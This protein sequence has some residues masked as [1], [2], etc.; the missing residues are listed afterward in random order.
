LARWTFF[1]LPV[2]H[3]RYLRCNQRSVFQLF[4]FSISYRGVGPAIVLILEVR[5]EES[6]K[7]A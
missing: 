7:K 4:L 5:M 3:W 2:H 1:Q 6:F